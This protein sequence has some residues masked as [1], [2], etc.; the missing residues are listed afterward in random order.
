MGN[1]SANVRVEFIALDL[2]FG[3]SEWKAQFTCNDVQKHWRKINQLVL[4]MHLGNHS[5]VRQVLTFTW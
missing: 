4:M 2:T 3:M 5:I 1:T